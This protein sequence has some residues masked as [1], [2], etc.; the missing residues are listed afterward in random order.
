MGA[1]DGRRVVGADSPGKA[2]LGLQ[3]P[4]SAQLDTGLVLIRMEVFLVSFCF[5]FLILGV[6]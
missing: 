2:T 4:A 1:S 3:A 5:V 6:G